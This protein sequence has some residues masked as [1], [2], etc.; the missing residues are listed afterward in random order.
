M[1]FLGGAGKAAEPQP[2]GSSARDLPSWQKA[3]ILF[4]V[5]WNCFVVTSTSTSL[6]VATPEIAATFRSTVETINVT[7]APVLIAMGC[8]TLIW[9]P[10][11]E[12]FSRRL[13]YNIALA[14]MF[15]TSVGTALAPN[16]STF[17][18]MRI[19][20]G[21]TGT[22][23]MVAGQTIIA[24]MFVS[25]VRGRAVGCMMAGSVAGTALGT[26]N[27]LDPPEYYFC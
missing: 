6:F 11:A 20:T 16:V 27:V 18:S 23:F 2:P 19:L 12:I 7:N 5:S 15:A 1:A 10:L 21:L 25:V 22:Y 13:S 9:A 26:F 4:I 24:D 17:T 3:T 14:V 8:S